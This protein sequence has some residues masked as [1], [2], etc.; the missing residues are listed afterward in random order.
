[1]FAELSDELQ[2]NLSQSTT[3][4]NE[5]EAKGRPP[6]NYRIVLREYTGITGLPLIRNKN[7][8]LIYAALNLI[9]LFIYISRFTL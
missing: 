3:T 6:V 7:G 4:D 9:S 5:S 2:W 8:P 1:M